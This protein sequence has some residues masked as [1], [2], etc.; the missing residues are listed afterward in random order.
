MLETKAAATANQAVI[1]LAQRA[2]KMTRD[3]ECTLGAFWRRRSCHDGR[4]GKDN[5]MPA[6]VGPASKNPTTWPKSSPAFVR[7]WQSTIG[8]TACRG[9]V[10]GESQYLRWQNE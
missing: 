5:A 6:G 1:L 10:S 4:T 9:R 3:M 2:A 7:S 8:A